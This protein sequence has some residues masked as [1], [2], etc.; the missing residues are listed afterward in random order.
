MIELDDDEDG[1]P[2]TTLLVDELDHAPAGSPRLPPKA[3]TARRM[4]ADVIAARGEA[5]PPADGFPPG[6]RG[7]REDDWRDECETRRLSGA[8]EK[9]DRKKAFHRAYQDLLEAREVAARD[10][11]V[12][13]VRIKDGET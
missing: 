3:N 9:R 1:D 4:L 5:L 10:G 12:W 8:A 13:L 2:I 7:C 6:L 11:W